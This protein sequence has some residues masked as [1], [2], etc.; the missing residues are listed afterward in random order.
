[1]ARRQLQLLHVNK[2][3]T[4]GLLLEPFSVMFLYVYNETFCRNYISIITVNREKMP[5]YEKVGAV[6]STLVIIM[7]LQ[8]K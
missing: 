8:T 1:M 5:D 7:K 6:G 2:I 3:P 4:K